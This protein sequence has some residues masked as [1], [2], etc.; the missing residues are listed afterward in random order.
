MARIVIKKAHEPM[1]IKKDSW[2]CMC[3]LSK[4]QPF[5]DSSHKKTT[6]EGDDTFFYSDSDRFEVD[7][8]RAVGKGCCGS[9]GGCAG[10]SH[11]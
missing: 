6:D 10:C 11:K 3:G 5:C 4:N 8:I 9:E 7:E 2:V 1:E